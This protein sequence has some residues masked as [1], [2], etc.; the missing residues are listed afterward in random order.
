MERLHVDFH[1]HVPGAEKLFLK[2][3]NIKHG[4]RW[5]SSLLVKCYSVIK[6]ATGLRKVVRHA[7][8][9]LRRLGLDNFGENNCNTVVVF[10]V[11]GTF[12]FPIISPNPNFP[13]TRNT[14][15]IGL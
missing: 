10:S 3:I 12:Q 6:M 11:L 2:G 5:T 8:K 14:F 9:R 4:L 7:Q 13:H 15:K 1:I